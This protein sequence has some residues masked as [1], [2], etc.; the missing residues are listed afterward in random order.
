MSQKLLQIIYKKLH[1]LF[2]QKVIF[3]IILQNGI[4][5][6]KYNLQ[7]LRFVHNYESD[8][9]DKQIMVNEENVLGVKK[10]PLSSGFYVCTSI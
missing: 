8:I 6:Q 2:N 9:N 7:N 3:L 4:K 5:C 10:N 1:D